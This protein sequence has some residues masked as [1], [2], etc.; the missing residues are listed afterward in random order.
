MAATSAPPRVCDVFLSHNSE[1]KPEVLKLFKSLRKRHIDVWIDSSE[2]IAGDQFQE[3]IEEALRSAKTCILCIGRNGYGPWQNEEMRAVINRRTRERNSGFRV[4]PVLLPGATRGEKSALP[5]FLQSTIWVEFAAIDDRNA[6]EQLVRGIRGTRGDRSTRTD[7][8]ACPY[9]GL[10]AFDVKSAGF[11]FGREALTEWLISKLKTTLDAKSRMRFLAILGP[12]G[13]GKS[14]LGASWRSCGAAEG[15]RQEE[16]HLGI[17]RLS[18]G[19]RP[20][21]NVSR[22]TGTLAGSPCSSMGPVTVR[23]SDESAELALVRAN[24]AM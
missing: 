5:E 16:R 23:S 13:S 6:L 21:R 14:S 22:S 7:T 2:L 18:P 15:F 24:A 10:H 11:F 19:A 20:H 8:T 4:I 17:L 1:D 3:R 12:S 9:G